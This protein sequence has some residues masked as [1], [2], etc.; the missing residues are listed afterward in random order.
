MSL[1]MA[2]WLRLRE[3][4]DADARAGGLLAPVRDRLAGPLVIHDLGC[5]TGSMGRWL[6]ARLPGPQHW[7]VSDRDPELLK[8][9][10]EQ[11][12][13]AAGDGSAVTLEVREQDITTL[14]ARDLAGV[15]LITASALLDMLTRDELERIAAAC[16]GAGCPALLSLSVTGQVRLDPP[17]PLDGAIGA[18]F[19]DHQR[20]DPGGGPLLGPDAP[21]LAVAAF[22][23]LGARVLV[24]PSPW[25]LGPQPAALTAEYLRQWVGAAVEHDPRLAGPAAG[26]LDRRLA[27]VAAGTL[28]IEVGH[29]DLFASPAG[30]PPAPHET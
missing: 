1:S 13:T 24:R 6:A 20:R 21:D 19:N 27:A 22:T 5:G 25:R 4:A 14:T 11:A 12:P 9:A 15:H 2:Q 10:A 30:E 23:R 16:T 28:R 18:A 3:D 7:I 17:D 8:L 29:C 26:Y